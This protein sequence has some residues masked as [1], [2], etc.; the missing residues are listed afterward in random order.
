[1]SSGL[2]GIGMKIEWSLVS[3]STAFG[4]NL[5]QGLSN[6]TNRLH[7]T[8]FVIGIHNGNQ[9]RFRTHGFFQIIHFNKTLPIYPNK[10]YGS[11]NSS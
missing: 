2:R 1:M 9:N 10:S 11:V 6:P 5:M 8:H 7:R 3:G 4:A